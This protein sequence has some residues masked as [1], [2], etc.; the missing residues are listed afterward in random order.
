MPLT[1]ALSFNYIQMHPFS[2]PRLVEC[3][4]GSLCTESIMQV[5]CQIRVDRN[6]NGCLLAWQ[7][8]FG[9][10]VS[11]KFLAL[12]FDTTVRGYLLNIKA[13]VLLRFLEINGTLIPHSRYIPHS[14]KDVQCNIHL[15]TPPISENIFDSEA[16]M[17]TELQKANDKRSLSKVVSLL[18]KPC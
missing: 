13:I 8:E 6:G 4:Q 7:R 5:V 17:I 11:F 14:F 12:C 16:L 2:G 15:F 10:S 18:S 9:E 3:Q 1:F